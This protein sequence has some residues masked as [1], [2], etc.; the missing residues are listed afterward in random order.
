[1]VDTRSAEPR[2]MDLT[3]PAA[4]RIY[5]SFLGG[6]HNF[7]VDREVVER[8]GGELP[9][10][11]ESYWEN[12]A[13]LRRAV[14]FM[15]AHGVR[16]FLDLGSG[17][18]TI[19]PVH[20]IARRRTREFRVVYVENEPLTVAHSRPLLAAEPNATIIHDDLRAPDS[21]LRTSQVR[22]FLDLDRPIGLL[23][24][25]VLHFVPDTDR[26]AELVEAYRDALAPGSHLLIS[27]LTDSHDPA[28]MQVLTGFYMESSDP[29]H[30][31]G[32]SVVEKF[33]GDFEQVPPGPALLSDWR[34]EPGARDRPT[35]ALLH[36][37]VARKP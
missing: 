24:S 33:F 4:A 29:M 5:D 22:Q 30:P 3:R 15:L 35:Y 8:I 14:E 26:P 13:F 20:E 19:G 31:R 34:P 16:Q 32:T 23:M 10:I 6:S 36:G 21:V 25:A 12:R 2:A 17:I 28:A 27:H 1:M 9:G 7:G 11:G 18:P 37:G